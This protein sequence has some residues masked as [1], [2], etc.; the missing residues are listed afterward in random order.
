ME[1]LFLSLSSPA[2]FSFDHSL[3]WNLEQAK[4]MDS[5]KHRIYLYGVTQND[6]ET[7]DNEAV[8]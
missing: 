1:K 8:T 3:I 4:E 5:P 6:I 7:W 2:R